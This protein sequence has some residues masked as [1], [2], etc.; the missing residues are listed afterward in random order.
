MA[1]RP[2]QKLPSI[3]EELTRIL[4]TP[5]ILK[6]KAFCNTSCSCMSKELAHNSQR[7]ICHSSKSPASD[8][9]TINDHFGITHCFLRVRVYDRR[10]SADSL[11][12][13]QYTNDKALTRLR[14]EA[15]D[16]YR[17]WITFSKPCLCR[18]PGEEQTAPY[19][20]PAESCSLRRFLRIFDLCSRSTPATPP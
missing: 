16:I 17:L 15:G 10:M 18:T 6:N 7:K 8:Q 5:G 13:Y 1:W 2:L 3:R 4:L 19:I 14:L 12:L 11:I 20:L 9:S